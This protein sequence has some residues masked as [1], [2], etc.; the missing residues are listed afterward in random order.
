ML[1]AS[2]KAVLIALALKRVTTCCSRKKLNPQVGKEPMLR[3]IGFEAALV[4][5]IAIALQ[6]IAPA[7]IRFKKSG[8]LL[9]TGAVQTYVHVTLR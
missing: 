5:L 1:A 7:A 6:T 2:I 9:G 4:V 8:Y 3:K